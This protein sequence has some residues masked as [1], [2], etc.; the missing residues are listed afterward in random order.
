MKDGLRQKLNDWIKSENGN[1][2]SINAIEQQVKIWGYK[3]SNY[4]R[5]LRDSESPGVGKVKK[6]GAIVGYYWIDNKGS[7]SDRGS[8]L[9]VKQPGF[10]PSVGATPTAPTKFCFYCFRKMAH[11]VNVICRKE[12]TPTS[13]PMNSQGSLFR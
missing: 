8:G 9:P 6:D 4:E 2:V 12:K 5:R 7:Y 1:V 10:V 3:I 11:P 13:T